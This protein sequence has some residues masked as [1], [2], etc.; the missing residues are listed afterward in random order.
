[1]AGQDDRVDVL[2]KFEP[3]FRTSPFL[4]LIR[5]F[6]H[7]K[8]G[9]ASSWGSTCCRSTPTLGALLTGDCC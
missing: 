5:P 7:R 2:A 1:V 3:P 6:F 4:N 9:E 8:E